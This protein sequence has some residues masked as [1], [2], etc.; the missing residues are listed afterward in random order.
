MSRQTLFRFPICISTLDLILVKAAF[1]EQTRGETTDASIRQTWLS[2]NSGL[3]CASLEAN[4]QLICIKSSDMLG[5][6]SQQHNNTSFL[7]VFQQRRKDLSF[8]SLRPTKP[9][10]HLRPAPHVP[11]I[12]KPNQY[13]TA[14]GGGNMWRAQKRRRANILVSIAIMSPF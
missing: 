5:P 9:E 7:K 12:L 3:K 10:K 2:N 8:Q 14:T 6:G 1:S 4:E 11:L 13:P